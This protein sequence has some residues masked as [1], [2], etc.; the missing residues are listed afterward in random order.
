[1]NL[2]GFYYRNSTVCLL[3]AGSNISS[4]FWHKHINI[5]E[6]PVAFTFGVKV[7]SLFYPEDL[8]SWFL[9]KFANFHQTTCCHISDVCNLNIHHFDNLYSHNR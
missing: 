6:D 3:F 9:Q 4:H 2:F 5:S 7:F 8:G 1:M